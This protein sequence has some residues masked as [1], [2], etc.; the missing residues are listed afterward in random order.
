MNIK[1]LDY[2]IHL[3]D[4]K[5][6]SKV[7]TAFGVSQPTITFA[8]QRLEKDFGTVLMI[9]H[10]AHG[11]LSLTD[12]GEQLLVHARTIVSEYQIAQRE[13]GEKQ[14]GRLTLGLPPIIENTYFPQI[15]IKLKQA[16]LLEKLYTY[17][18]GSMTTLQALN[19]GNI[20]LA[21]LATIEPL[22]DDRF[23]VEPF[24]RQP[25]A[26]YVSKDHPLA[27][28]TGVR[29][30]DLKGESFLLF[31]QGFVHNQAFNQLTRANHIRPKIAFRSNSL[32]GLLHLIANNIGIGFLSIPT[33]VTPDV[34]R[35]PLTDA[36]QPEFITSLVYRRSHVFNPL[37]QQMLTLIRTSLNQ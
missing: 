17:E 1:D 23:V 35:V 30:E 10:R 19:A 12:S 25:F 18:E 4:Q 22:V 28:R 9:R 29:F 37:Q 11:E 36:D 20:D 8:L 31:K 26:I 2:F 24:H 5:S 27:Q 32:E 15:A 34:V 16:G 7:A 6:F 21:M 33:P 14:R 3:A 13:L